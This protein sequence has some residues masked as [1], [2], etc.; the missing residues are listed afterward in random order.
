MESPE[1]DTQ[2]M[3]LG[4]KNGFGCPLVFLEMFGFAGWP[5]SIR[6][7]K[8]TWLFLSFFFFLH[9]LS[10]TIKKKNE[11]DFIIINLI[12]LEASRFCIMEHMEAHNSKQ[13]RLLKYK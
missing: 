2:R 1:L 5:V 9:Q 10:V 7:V 8:N 4:C 11:L 12:L 3:Y 6:R 13:Y